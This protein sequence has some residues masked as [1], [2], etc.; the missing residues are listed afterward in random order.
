VRALEYGPCLGVVLVTWLRRR[1][2]GT[3]KAAWAAT[4]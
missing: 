3:E 4:S 1:P 2:A